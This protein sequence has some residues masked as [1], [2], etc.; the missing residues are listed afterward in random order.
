M[1]W[2][3]LLVCSVILLIVAWLLF[4]P[5]G[6]PGTTGV[7]L[8]I[9]LGASDPELRLRVAKQLEHYNPRTED[10]AEG[11]RL[12]RYL[13][14]NLTDA[15]WPQAARSI[16]AGWERIHRTPGSQSLI[17][18]WAPALLEKMAPHL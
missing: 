6:V 16:Y 15:E 8:E 18:P 12:L 4:G 7:V 14:S 5:D 17:E 11:V 10:V 9:P 3:L 2:L 1:K 13:L